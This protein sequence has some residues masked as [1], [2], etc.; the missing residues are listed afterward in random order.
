MGTPA[1]GSN[2]IFAW[3][4]IGNS[5]KTRPPKVLNGDPVAR[6][7]AAMMHIYEF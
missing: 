5:S 4:V 1:I 2:A 7:A 3:S 6:F